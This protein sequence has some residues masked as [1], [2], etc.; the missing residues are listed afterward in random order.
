M[1]DFENGDVIKLHRIDNE[2]VSEHVLELFIDG[3]RLIGAY[4]T[5]RDSVVFTNKRV[6]AVNVQGTTG[7]KTDYLSLPYSKITAYSVE[8]S[9]VIDIDSEL[10]LYFSGLGQ[11]AFEFTGTSDVRE[12]CRVISEFIL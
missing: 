9:G 12:I 8:T 10:E 5:M 1:I 2:D 7:K 6:I 4:K 11:V 3:E